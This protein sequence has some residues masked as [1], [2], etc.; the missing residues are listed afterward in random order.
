MSEFDPLAQKIVDVL[1]AHSKEEEKTRLKEWLNECGQLVD[2][3][4]RYDL[5]FQLGQSL[6][7]VF[8]RRITNE[9]QQAMVDAYEAWVVNPTTATKYELTKQ[10]KRISRDRADRNESSYVSSALHCLGRIAYS[11]ND[12]ARVVDNIIFATTYD[13]DTQKAMSQAR[14]SRSKDHVGYGEWLESLKL[15]VPGMDK[16]ASP[17]RIALLNF[18]LDEYQRILTT[19]IIH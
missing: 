7:R 12:L 1:S 4:N 11:K 5:Y 17:Q 10:L 6:L 15:S 18:C 16:I 9:R 19:P 14:L 13:E 3:R 8:S 2:Y